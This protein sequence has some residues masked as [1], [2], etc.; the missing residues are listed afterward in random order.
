VSETS[1]V[2][3]MKEKIPWLRE[4]RGKVILLASFVFPFCGCLFLFWWI[5]RIHPYGAVISQMALSILASVISYYVM[6]HAIYRLRDQSKLTHQLPN[7]ATPFY[8]ALVIAPIFVLMIHPLMVSGERLLPIWVAIP[9]GL[10]LIVFGLLIRRSAMTGSGFSIGHAFG[11]YLV[12]PEDGILVDKEVYAYLRHP[13]SA[14]VI[15]IA[16]GF[17]FVRNSMLA[18]LTALIYLIPILVEMKL[19][20]DELM[21]RFG[22]AH[23]RYMMETR[24]FIPHWQDFGRLMKLIFFRG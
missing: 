19:E 21:D 16:I 20:D 12:F 1:S 5:D 8:I 3:F 24:A 14:G 7:W 18:I 10:F 4:D 15:C 22:D 23:R 11:I 2:D 13:L 6:R 9:L 17:G